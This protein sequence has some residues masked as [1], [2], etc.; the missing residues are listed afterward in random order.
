MANYLLLPPFLPSSA[1]AEDDVRGFD[2]PSRLAL[3]FAFLAVAL[4][5]PFFSV[6]LP[7]FGMTGNARLADRFRNEFGHTDG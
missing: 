4:P 5:C 2:L 6:M 3:A 7:S 1:C